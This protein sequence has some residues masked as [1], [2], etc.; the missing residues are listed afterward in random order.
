M[1]PTSAQPLLSRGLGLHGTLCL[2]DLDSWGRREFLETA[3][4]V[5]RGL[6]PVCPSTQVQPGFQRW[7]L[8]ELRLR[9]HR[10][11]FPHLACVALSTACPFSGTPPPPPPHVPQN[12]PTLAWRWFCHNPWVRETP[13]VLLRHRRLPRSSSPLSPGGSHPQKGPAGGQ[14]RLSEPGSRLVSRRFGL[15]ILRL[16]S[17]CEMD[18]SGTCEPRACFCLPRFHP[19]C[20]RGLL[21]P[22]L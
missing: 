11:F 17:W 7:P 5:A 1:E 9:G 16:A 20:P 13:R 2:T 15:S 3:V 18:T 19:H 10:A 22:R 12:L 14:S 4:H 6:R 21:T 8:C